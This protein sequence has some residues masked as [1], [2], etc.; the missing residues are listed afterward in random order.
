M[1][2]PAPVAGDWGKGLAPLEQRCGE[3]VGLL[4]DRAC[5]TPASRGRFGVFAAGLGRPA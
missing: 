4:G 1:E 2:T 3:G 5:V